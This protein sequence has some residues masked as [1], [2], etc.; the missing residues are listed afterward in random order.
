MVPG[1]VKV[2]EEEEVV[3][4]QIFFDLPFA[5]AGKPSARQDDPAR[6]FDKGQIDQVVLKRLDVPKH[7]E[8]SAQNPCLP[9]LHGSDDIH[10]VDFAVDVAHRPPILRRFS[11][12]VGWR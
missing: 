4:F 11:D 12:P 9:W 7:K 1:P 2:A 3:V 6:E 8:E 10:R 5:E